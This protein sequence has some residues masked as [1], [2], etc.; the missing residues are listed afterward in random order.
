MSRPIPDLRECKTE[1][2]RLLAA[3]L[4][5]DVAVA[6][7]AAKRLQ[8]A[9]TLAGRSVEEILATRETIQLKHAQAA[10]ARE[11]RYID[12]KALKDATDIVWYPRNASVFLNA[13]F[14]HYEQAR[15]HLDARGGYLLTHRGDYFVC[16]EEFIRAR[17]LDPADPRWE[18]IGY[19]VA[20]PRDRRACDELRAL[21]EAESKKFCENPPR[22]KPA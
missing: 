3:L 5:D 19:D 2:K 22:V 10:V 1:S 15:A 16:G 14:A 20:K 4:S 13:W 12:W 18:T 7:A 9:L 17:G 21:A 6:H 11:Q 8:A